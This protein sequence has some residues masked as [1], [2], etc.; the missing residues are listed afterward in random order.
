[1]SFWKVAPQNVSSNTQQR[2][3]ATRRKRSR[4]RH[5]NASH[6][7]RKAN[8]RTESEAAVVTIPVYMWLPIVATYVVADNSSWYHAF[9]PFDGVKWSRHQM[10]SLLQ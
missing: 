5:R 7:R 6:K 1:M 9:S 2:L 10:Q 4:N 3:Q 8:N